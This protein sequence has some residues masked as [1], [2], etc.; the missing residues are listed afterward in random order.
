[1]KEKNKAIVWISFRINKVLFI[2]LS[3]L[4]EYTLSFQ[5]SSNLDFW[6]CSFHYISLLILSHQSSIDGVSGFSYLFV[7]AFLAATLRISNWYFALKATVVSWW[8][9]WLIV[10]IYLVLGVNSLT[11]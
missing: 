6:K 7:I 8:L 4:E 11:R 5:V 3:I 10:W 2:F 9:P 1:M